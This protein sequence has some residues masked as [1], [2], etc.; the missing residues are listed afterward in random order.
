MQNNP[1]YPIFENTWDALGFSFYMEVLPAGN[2]SSTY[3]AIKHMME[4]SGKVFDRVD[5]RIKMTGLTPYDVRAQCA[6]IRAVVEDYL[7]VPEKYAVW[8]QH[9]VAQ[10][11]IKGINGV[12]S[13][14]ES[15][16]NKGECLKMIVALVY[17]KA[18]TIRSVATEYGVSKSS[19]GE[20]LW[21]VKAAVDSMEKIAQT[22]LEEIF[23]KGGLI[24]DPLAV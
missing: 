5:S 8:A 16:V 17:T 14:I 10:T 15:T 24:V 19:V 21:R 7:T 2:I 3:T 11:K 1:Q 6:M 9:G 20:D 12:A 4:S 22:R 13:Y 23:R 18:I